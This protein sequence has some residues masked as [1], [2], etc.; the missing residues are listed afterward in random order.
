M[1]EKIINCFVSKGE[2]I[3]SEHF[4]IKGIFIIDSVFLASNN[5]RTDPSLVAVIK[6]H[7]KEHNTYRVEATCDKFI[8]HITLKDQ[9]LCKI[10]SLKDKNY[11]NI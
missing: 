3:Y 8:F 7:H 10:E 6:A 9:R 5:I 1:G 2:E 4:K 11:E